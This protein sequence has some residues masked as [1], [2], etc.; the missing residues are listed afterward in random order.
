MSLLFKYPRQN[1]P[2]VIVTA[3]V[4]DPVKWEAG[5][6]THGYLFRTY[7]PEVLGAQAR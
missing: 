1:M 2:K 3:Q 4:Q 6:R 5:F 7:T